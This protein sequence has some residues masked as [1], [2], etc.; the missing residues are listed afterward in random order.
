[1]NISLS[2]ER[3]ISIDPQRCVRV[4]SAVEHDSQVEG[5]THG[6][7]LRNFQIADR[8]LAARLTALGGCANGARVDFDIG[9]P[10]KLGFLGRAF[11]VL[12]AI[13]NQDESASRAFG[14]K[15][16]CESQSGGDI[17]VVT[18]R[19]RADIADA[20]IAERLFASGREF[21]GR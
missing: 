19:V 17:G 7:L 12:V 1:M 4:A 20:P 14:N 2:H 5:F 16:G 3:I 10:K 18:G 13:R 11:E 8:N 9:R 21:D 6:E 15:G